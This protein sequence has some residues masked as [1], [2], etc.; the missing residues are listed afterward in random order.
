M[1]LNKAYRINV[2]IPW[3]ICVSFIIKKRREINPVATSILEVPSKYL[4]LITAW[5]G[6]LPISLTLLLTTHKVSNDYCE[7]SSS[8]ELS[9]FSR[10]GL[11]T[12]Q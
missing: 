2:F 5:E 4:T 11:S 7:I 3:F 9:L 12:K 1:S 10:K 8:L 6:M